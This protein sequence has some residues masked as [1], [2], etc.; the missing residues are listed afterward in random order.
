MK[1]PGL[2]QR[3][4]A[5]QPANAREH[6]AQGAQGRFLLQ[7]KLP[8]PFGRTMPDADAKPARMGAGERCD[9][10]G[11]YSRMA[12]QRR[13]DADADGDAR[14]GRE[15]HG[16]RGKPAVIEIVFVDPEFVETVLLGEPVGLD[17][18]RD[19]YGAR[20]RN[21]DR[22]TVRHGNS[23]LRPIAAGASFEGHVALRNTSVGG[24]PAPPIPS[25]GR[26]ATARGA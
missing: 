22:K 17:K 5:E 10:H 3:L 12:H 23:P 11:R 26:I 14:G 24:Y 25:F 8:H 20:E 15:R 1:E 6:L 9:L 21:A 7:S 16:R 18:T 2:G 4:S 19:R 13:D